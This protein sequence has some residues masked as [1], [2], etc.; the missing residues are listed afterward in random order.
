MHED[1]T[2]SYVQPPAATRP[3]GATFWSY[4][5]IAWA[6]NKPDGYRGW[7]RGGPKAAMAP[8]ADASGP[9]YGS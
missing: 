9:S 8:G 6:P 3:T 2:F 7:P 4:T 5:R 1:V